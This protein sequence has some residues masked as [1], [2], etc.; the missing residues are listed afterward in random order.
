MDDIYII[1]LD[2]VGGRGTIVQQWEYR[3]TLIV[4]S[5]SQ[6]SYGARSKYEKGKG[7]EEVNVTQN[8]SA[9]GSASNDKK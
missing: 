1:Y 6:Q 9:F 8:I 2:V 3:F 5:G 7:E 4:Y